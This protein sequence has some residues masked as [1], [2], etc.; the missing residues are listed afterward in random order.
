LSSRFKE[1]FST[2]AIPPS[3]PVSGESHPT[4]TIVPG[5]PVPPASAGNDRPPREVKPRK[6]LPPLPGQDGESQFFTTSASSYEQGKDFGSNFRVKPR[7]GTAPENPP[8]AFTFKGLR[9]F[10]RTRTSSSD[11]SNKAAGI[12][13]KK[14]KDRFLPSSKRRGRQSGDDEWDWDM[15]PS[16]SSPENTESSQAPPYTVGGGVY[17]VSGGTHP[18]TNDRYHSNSDV[19]DLR[20]QIDYIMRTLQ[21]MES[22]Q[23]HHSQRQEDLTNYMRQVDYWFSRAP[24]FGSPYL[25]RQPPP[26]MVSSSPPRFPTGQP[27]MVLQPPP[28]AMPGI[29]TVMPGAAPVHLPSQHYPYI[30]PPPVIVVPGSER[31]Q[32]QP[33]SPRYS[34]TAPVIHAGPTSFPSHRPKFSAS[35]L[36]HFEDHESSPPVRVIEHLHTGEA[37][38]P[39]IRQFENS[40][41]RLQPENGSEGKD[42]AQ[43]GVILETRKTIAIKPVNFQPRNGTRAS[44]R[45]LM[46][47]L[48]DWLRLWGSLEHEN[49]TK[50]LGSAFVN[51]VPSVITEWCTDGNIMQYLEKTPQADR[52][53][54]LHQA[55]LGLNYLHTASPWMIHSNLK[56]KNVL[57]DGGRVKLADI[58]ILKFLETQDVGAET[59]GRMGDARWT[60]PEILEGRD[61][62]WQ[63]DVYSFGCLAL[64]ILRDELPYASL[65]RDV[66]VSKAIYRGDLP[67]NREAAS[68][69]D[70]TWKLCWAQDP[71]RRPN[72]SAILDSLAAW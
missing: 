24:A 70:P 41:I 37:G 71:Q 51:E 46:S 38:L 48:N 22:T 5:P 55:A 27:A 8:S 44:E 7:S 33:T 63:S 18:M 47:E 26:I 13:L 6:E 39:A 45:A 29:V 56:P 67:I 20:Q 9:S 64:F 60:A 23:E 11:S 30:P 35:T 28:H 3:R 19:A 43:K 16:Q 59:H 58:G 50:M 15:V 12:D 57:V 32:H 42:Q 49:I 62:L 52:R 40:E 25:S 4:I 54:L 2:V 1:Q 36:R 21:R 68:G 61:H 10:K 65:R 34:P 72:M 66:A 69:L 14:L 31:D 53:S 17:P